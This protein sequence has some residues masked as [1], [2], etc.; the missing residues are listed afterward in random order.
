MLIGLKLVV[1]STAKKIAAELAAFYGLK[2]NDHEVLDI[3]QSS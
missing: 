3:L 2:N 1:P